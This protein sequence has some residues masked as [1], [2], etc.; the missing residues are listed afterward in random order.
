MPTLRLLSVF[1][2]FGG[3]LR[4]WRRLE[5]S[6]SDL[7]TYNIKPIDIDC[8]LDCSSFFGLSSF[9]IRIL[10][11]SPR[12]ELQGRLQVHHGLLYRVIGFAVE[13]YSS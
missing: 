2:A 3:G 13:G 5:G 8:S 7:I 11:G 6:P 1:W 12:R 9:I 10:E 4:L